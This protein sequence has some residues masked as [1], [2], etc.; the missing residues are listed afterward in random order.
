MEAARQAAL[1]A[2]EVYNK[3]YITEGIAQGI[4]GTGRMLNRADQAIG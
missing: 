3:G 1:K 2:N 4:E